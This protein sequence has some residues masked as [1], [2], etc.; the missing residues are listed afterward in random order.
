MTGFFEEEFMAALDALRK[1]P[2]MS[3]DE[4]YS[5]RR[6]IAKKCT[7][8][9]SFPRQFRNALFSFRALFN[10]DVGLAAAGVHDY[11]IQHITYSNP[12]PSSSDITLECVKHF[13]D[14]EERL[15]NYYGT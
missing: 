1:N 15:I 2:G 5:Y 7:D 8:I 10:E 4:L 12:T 6:V 11:I 9:S 14:L 13:N 3:S